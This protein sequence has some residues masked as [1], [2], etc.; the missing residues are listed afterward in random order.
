MENAT[1]TIESALEKGQEVKNQ[2]Q[3]V[4]ERTSAALHAASDKGSEVW[5]DTVDFVR[6]NPAQAIGA[7]IA[8]GAALGVLA[9]ALLTRRESSPYSRLRKITE[10]SQDGWDT[11]KDAMEKGLTGLK[12]AL[13]EVQA[14]LK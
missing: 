2:Y 13:H 11:V 7:S 8:A 6:R 1:R 3:N 4:K 12:E 14:S 9:Y 10:A 5:G